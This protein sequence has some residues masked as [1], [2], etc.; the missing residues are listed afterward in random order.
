MYFSH[1]CVCATKYFPTDS[2][3]PVWRVYCVKYVSPVEREAIFLW[4]GS[5]FSGTPFFIEFER[6]AIFST[7]C[8]N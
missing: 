4:T 5:H 2:T 8:E 3:A 1:F 7:F 6:E